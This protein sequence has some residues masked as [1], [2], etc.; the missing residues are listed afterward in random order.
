MK[1]KNVGFFVVVSLF[2]GSPLFGQPVA[3]SGKKLVVSPG[4]KMARLLGGEEAGP[5]GGLLARA[6]DV[7][8]K[9]VDARHEAMKKA[10]KDWRALVRGARRALRRKKFRRVEN[11]IKR[12]RAE[13]A[14]SGLLT[15]KE[16]TRLPSF[17]VPKGFVGG[18]TL[19][20]HRVGA[21]RP[22]RPGRS[23]KPFRIPR[24]GKKPPF[25]TK[26]LPTSTAPAEEEPEEE[27]KFEARIPEE[28]YEEEPEEEAEEE[29]P[30]FN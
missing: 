7:L 27:G 11:R 18:V 4:S 8:E 26:K 29:E 15:K 16:L 23:P 21:P 28:D 17:E 6:E 20:P 19:P 9:I 14:K 3:A 5:R 22:V 1:F 30:I 25:I 24:K 2:V 13:L 12:L 10:R